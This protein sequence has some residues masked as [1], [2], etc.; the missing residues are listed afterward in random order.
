M[1]IESI[2]SIVTYRTVGRFRNIV[3]ASRD[4]A[5][6]LVQ[7][8]RCL[9]VNRVFGRDAYR[10]GPR[11][12]GVGQASDV[13]LFLTKPSECGWGRDGDCRAAVYKPREVARKGYL[14]I[15]GMGGM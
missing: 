10:L 12:H 1:C 8:C 15:G 4:L 11:F 6:A 9:Y 13:A 7:T 14:T 5:Y 3:R 2:G